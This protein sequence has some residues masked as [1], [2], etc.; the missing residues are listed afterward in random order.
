MIS[1]ATTVIV[2]GVFFAAAGWLASPT[3]R[4]AKRAG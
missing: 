1:I 3:G 2:V 4:P